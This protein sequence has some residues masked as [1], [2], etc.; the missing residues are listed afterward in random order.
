MPPSI[1]FT[2]VSF[3]S[4]EFVIM[5]VFDWSFCTLTFP[6]ASQSPLKLML[7]SDGLTAVEPSPSVSET[8]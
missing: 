1:T 3:G 2:T 8:T 6:S 4:F 5:Q 7:Q